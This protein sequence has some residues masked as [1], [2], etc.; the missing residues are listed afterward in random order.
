[1]FE[2]IFS[3]L[4]YSGYAIVNNVPIPLL[5]GNATENEN[6]IKSAGSYHYD[7]AFAIG[8]LPAKNRRSLPLSFSTFICPMTMPLVKA[9][10]YGWRTLSLMDMV[11]E[12]QFALFP[13]AGEGYSGSGYV[14]ELT[15]A[16]SPE[17]LVSLNISMTC[18]VWQEIPSPQPLQRTGAALAPMSNVYKP[19]AGWQTIPNFSVISPNAIPMSWSLTLHN[20][21]TYQAFLAGYTQPPNPGLITAGDLDATF[22]ISWLA[23]RNSRPAD[24]GSLQ[25]QIGTPQIDKIYIDNLIRDPQRAFT[26]I[27]APNEPVKWDASYYAQGSIPRSN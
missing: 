8:Q 25:L 16:G 9:L 4:G 3:G 17:S 19:I 26:G 15:I 14:E 24:T 6:I 23:A 18:W 21:W 11:G 20:N 22:T 7:P 13:A 2:T 10:T 5:P 1:M 27:G 12:T